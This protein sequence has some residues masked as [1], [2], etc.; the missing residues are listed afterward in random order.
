MRAISVAI[1]QAAVATPPPLPFPSPK[2]IAVSLI[3]SDV[4]RV[5]VEGYFAVTSNTVQFGA[6]VEIFFGFDAINIQGHIAFDAEEIARYCTEHGIFLIE[7][8]AHAH[9]A[10]HSYVRH[11][12]RNPRSDGRPA[13]G[14]HSEHG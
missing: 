14:T 13:G 12:Q 10:A 11:H 7:D 2:R 1:A 9:G 4:A 8:C 3:N 6:A 5:R